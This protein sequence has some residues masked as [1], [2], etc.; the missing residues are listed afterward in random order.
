MTMR[1]PG[2][3]LPEYFIWNTLLLQCSSLS[4]GGVKNKECIRVKF[5]KKA[6]NFLNI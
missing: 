1:F 4:V 2:T 5:L 6:F 3:L